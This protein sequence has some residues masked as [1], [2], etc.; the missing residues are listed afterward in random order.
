MVVGSKRT[1]REARTLYQGVR[2]RPYF[3]RC[4]SSASTFDVETGVHGTL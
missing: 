3:E 4:A 2:V 1:H